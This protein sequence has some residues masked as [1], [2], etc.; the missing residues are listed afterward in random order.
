MDAGGE[1]SRDLGG[2]ESM[3]DP[4]GV[5]ERD[6]RDGVGDPIDI[7]NVNVHQPN[8]QQKISF[9]IFQRFKRYSRRLGKK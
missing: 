3:S 6:S 9:I 8:L 7:L 5:P 1:F 4:R 2:S